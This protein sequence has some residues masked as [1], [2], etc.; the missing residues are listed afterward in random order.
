MSME[1]VI[2]HVLEVIMAQQF[3]LKAALKKFDKRGKEAVTQGLK[4]LHD[5]VTSVSMDPKK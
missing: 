3:S 5:M 2:N 4:Q 1:E